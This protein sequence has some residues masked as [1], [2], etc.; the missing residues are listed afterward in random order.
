M[1][2]QEK[3]SIDKDGIPRAFIK[4]SGEADITAVEIALIDK[5]GKSMCYERGTMDCLSIEES[6]FSILTSDGVK[7]FA[8]SDPRIKSFKIVKYL[9][10]MKELAVVQK[11]CEEL[12]NRMRNV[13]AST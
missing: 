8:Y 4:D 6:T 9:D 13:R 5:T 1:R 12:Q 2:Q 11:R 3:I 10:L 7:T